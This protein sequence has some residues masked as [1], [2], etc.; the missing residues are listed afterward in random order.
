MK[1]A[2]FLFTL[3]NQYTQIDEVHPKIGS[4]GPELIWYFD[5]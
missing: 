2:S 3:A 1:Y 4:Y 5:I